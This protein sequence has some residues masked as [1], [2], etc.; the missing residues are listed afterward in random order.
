MRSRP[1]RGQR[2]LREGSELIEVPKEVRFAYG[3]LLRQRPELVAA[4]AAEP[5]EVLAWTFAE[6]ARAPFEH[7]G[8]QAEL[9]V[10]EPKSEPRL[11]GGAK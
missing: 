7:L 2:D 8:E 10:V 6:A 11:D 3:E 5:R 4:R 1:P 9:A